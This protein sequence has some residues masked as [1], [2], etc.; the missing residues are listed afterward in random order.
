MELDFGG[1]GKEYAV[2][3]AAAVLREMGIA[4]ALVNLGGDILVTG[5]A[6]G[7]APWRVGIR[8]P[9]RTGELVATLSVSSGALATSGDYE[10]FFVKDGVRYCHV[11]DPRSGH[12][13]QGF[14]SVSVLGET[15]LVAGSASTIAML[16]GERDGLAWLRAS[17][18]RHFCV[19]RDGAVHDATGVACA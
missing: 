2:D 8:H 17:G 11:L 3:R 13:V 14:Q 18:V 16:K 15:C 12:P 7:G 19:G 5:P 6:P 10:R 9:R 4:S 1:F